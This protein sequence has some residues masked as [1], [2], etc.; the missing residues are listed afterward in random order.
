MTLKE[1]IYDILKTYNITEEIIIDDG[2]EELIINALKQ[3]G[4]ES[5]FIDEEGGLVIDYGNE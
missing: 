4:I 2:A 1:E 3:E 5:V